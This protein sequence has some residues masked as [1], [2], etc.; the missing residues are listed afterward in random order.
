MFVIEAVKT[1]FHKREILKTQNVEKNKNRA[2]VLLGMNAALLQFLVKV[3]VT[4]ETSPKAVKGLNLGFHPM[5]QETFHLQQNN[6]Q[7]SRI[8]T[9][10]VLLQRYLF[11]Y[12]LIR[13]IDN[14]FIATN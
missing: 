8:P 11:P 7:H 13:N 1:N 9:L 10:T 4:Q 3:N 6:M 2:S 5:L 14:S 12:N